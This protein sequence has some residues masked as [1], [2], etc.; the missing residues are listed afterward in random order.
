MATESLVPR[1]LLAPV[2]WVLQLRSGRNFYFCRLHQT[3]ESGEAAESL[4]SV[5]LLKQAGWDYLLAGIDSHVDMKGEGR[6]R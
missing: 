3:L 4:V 6:V 1:H 5:S 2:A